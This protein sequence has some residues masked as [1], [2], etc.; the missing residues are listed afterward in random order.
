MQNFSVRKC[1]FRTVM[2]YV[3]GLIGLN[4]VALTSSAG[5]TVVEA[6]LDERFVEVAQRVPEFGGAFLDENGDL[7]VYLTKFNAEAAVKTALEDIFGPEITRRD[8]SKSLR[9]KRQRQT[10]PGEIRVLHGQYGFTELFDLRKRSLQALSVPGAVSLDI[11]ETQNRIKIGVS[12]TKAAASVESVLLSQ[13]VA[14]D[15]VKIELVEPIHSLL[16][17]RDPVFPPKGGIQIEFPVGTCTL[18]FNAFLGG[19]RGFV[20]NSHCTNVQGG[21]EGTVYNQP[22]G[23]A[24][25]IERVDPIYRG[26]FWFWDCPW[27]RS[28]RFSDSAFAEYFPATPSSFARI[29]RTTSYI[30]SLTID[31]ALPNFNIVGLAAQPL[32]GEEFDKVGR[33]TGWT[34]G[35]LVETC[36]DI[37]P[38][39]AGRDTGLTL[40]CQDVVS[41][42]G[43]GA[44]SLPGDSGS[45]VFVWLHEG[46]WENSNVLLAGILWGLTRVG[47]NNEFVFSR[48]GQ[49]QRADELGPLT[50]F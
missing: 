39:L 50:T 30:G 46:Q 1:S 42:V 45:P 3:I 6:S 47:R 26:S 12:D 48:I 34:F 49:I 18:G 43:P 44:I 38:T 8:N 27:F 32:V 5:P 41:A 10:K 40:K 25:G 23:G 4:L 24:I 16:S 37:N 36:V 22:G 28:C 19:V 17:V 20:T 14:L 13:G 31:D 2:I 11:D 33:T 29:A 7:N 35:R 9:T 15:A 21:V